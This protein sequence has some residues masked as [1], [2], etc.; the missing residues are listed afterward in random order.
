MKRDLKFQAEY[1]HPIERVW[2]AITSSEAIAAWLMPN[3]FQPRVGHKFQFRTKPQGGWDG[4]VHCAVL[5]CEPPRKLSYTWKSNML[6]TVLHITLEPLGAD[7]T[8]LILEH[9]GFSGMKA[10]LLSFLLGSGWGRILRKGIPGVLAR[11]DAAGHLAP[12][13]KS[14]GQ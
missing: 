8:R 7:R 3:D 12:R 11:L 10:V 9:Q 13:E 5:A 2:Q 6:D 1:D 4:I 14:A